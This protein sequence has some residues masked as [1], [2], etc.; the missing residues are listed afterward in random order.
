MK[1]GLSVFGLVCLMLCFVFTL[2]V[3][4]GDFCAR[5]ASA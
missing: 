5:W 2:F 1:Y 4:G 3:F